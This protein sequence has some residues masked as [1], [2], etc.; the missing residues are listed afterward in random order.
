VKPASAGGPSVMN[1]VTFL[2]GSNQGFLNIQ[3]IWA[4]AEAVVCSHYTSSSAAEPFHGLD[5]W[6]MSDVLQA[7]F[8]LSVLNLL[9]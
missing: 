5:M 3:P 1:E 6:P 9:L 2:S 4:Q 7:C 8:G